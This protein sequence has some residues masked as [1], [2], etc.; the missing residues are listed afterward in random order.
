MSSEQDYKAGLRKH[1]EQVQQAM[2]ALDEKW[3]D[4]SLSEVSEKFYKISSLSLQAGG[5]AYNLHQDGLYRQNVTR[6]LETVTVPAP[7][8]C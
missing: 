3:D 4:L 8:T 6:P 5:D 2:Q 7:A 1:L